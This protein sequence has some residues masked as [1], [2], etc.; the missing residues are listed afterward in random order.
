MIRS[1][2]SA[3]R[4]AVGGVVNDRS[5]LAPSV[6]LDPAHTAAVSGCTTALAGRRGASH[7]EVDAWL[8]RVVGW[9]TGHHAETVHLPAA[10]TTPGQEL[11]AWALL[12]DGV[13]GAAPVSAA[14]PLHRLNGAI[15]EGAAWVVALDPERFFAHALASMERADTPHGRRMAAR[16]RSPSANLSVV[17]GLVDTVALSL[18]LGPHP[19]LRMRLGCTDT[20]AAFQATVVLQAWRAKRAAGTD[21]AAPAFARAS[22]TRG[23]TR[24]EMT[25]PGSREDVLALVGPLPAA[26]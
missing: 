25:F 16:M 1:S 22:V 5:G 17:T 19:A 11:H 13:T 2:I 9:V 7:A 6:V 21:S 20:P 8:T 14:F 10:P 24:V 12:H 23:A 3:L 4:H 26:R 18:D 15:P